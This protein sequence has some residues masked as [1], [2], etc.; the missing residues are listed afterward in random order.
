MERP[1]RS[2][3]P[4]S[5]TGAGVWNCPDDMILKT[6]THTH[7]EKT[8]RCES[9]ALMAFIQAFFYCCVYPDRFSEGKR[10]ARSDQQIVQASTVSS[11]RPTPLM[12]LPSYIFNIF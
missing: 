8:K 4:G 7:E 6:H 10:I 12:L 3:R 11:S 2:C 5:L 1:Q 9:T